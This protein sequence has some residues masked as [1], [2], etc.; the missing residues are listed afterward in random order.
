MEKNGQGIPLFAVVLLLLA[1]GNDSN[2]QILKYICLT[3]DQNWSIPI[4]Q[5]DLLENIKTY[6]DCIKLRLTTLN[7]I[8]HPIQD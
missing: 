7:S 4:C 2:C 5:I 3:F 1:R 6:N 8:F